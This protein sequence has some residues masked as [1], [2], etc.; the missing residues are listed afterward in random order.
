MINSVLIRCNNGTVRGF[1]SLFDWLSEASE[2]T[3]FI[4][5]DGIS[6][7]VFNRRS[8][9]CCR[10]K[11]YR[12]IVLRVSI[13]CDYSDCIKMLINGFFNSV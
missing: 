7:K 1:L 10:K 12:I 6:I 11:H 8:E 3:R 5:N 9:R 13:E 2:L 4:I